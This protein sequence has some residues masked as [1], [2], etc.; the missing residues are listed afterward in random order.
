MKKRIAAGVLW[1]Y[2]GWVAGA[3]I[4]FVLGISPML[5]PIV[6]AA[7]TGLVVSDPRRLIWTDA[8]STTGRRLHAGSAA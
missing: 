5:A 4:A 7:A 8:P 2:A 3:M 6:A 1:F